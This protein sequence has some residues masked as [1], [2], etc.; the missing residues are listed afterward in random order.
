MDL[1]LAEY[2]KL[3]AKRVYLLYYID[4]FYKWCIVLDETTVHN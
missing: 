1:K 3:L 4:T 2:K